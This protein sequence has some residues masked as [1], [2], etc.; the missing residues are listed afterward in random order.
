MNR[1][2]F[3]FRNLAPLLTTVLGIVLLTAAQASASQPPPGRGEMS[4]TQ[5][6]RVTGSMHDVTNSAPTAHA[7]VLFSA[8]VLAALVV[9]A[10]L[11]QLAQ[12]RRA[13]PAH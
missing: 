10:V 2:V 5:H 1:T 9:G 6:R 12:R 3:P 13:Q 11:M 7:W 8:G 4:G